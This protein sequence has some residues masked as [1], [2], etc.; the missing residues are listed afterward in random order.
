VQAACS[1][2]G[3][4]LDFGSY[5]SGQAADLNGYT[6]LSYSNC[7]VGQIR[8]ELD[9]G[10]AGSTTARKLSN[11]SGSLLAYG[12]FRDSARSQNF[13]QGSDS[14][15]LTLTTAGS[16]NVSVYGRIPGGQVVPAGTYT[17]TVV[18]TLTF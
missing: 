15:I 7:P 13:G 11:A 2:A 4:T 3:A 5:A 10:R 6:Q 17:D 12:I 8:F 18:V 9:G 1:I 14:R 16:G